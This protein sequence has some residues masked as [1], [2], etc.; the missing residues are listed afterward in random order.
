MS[1]YKPVMKLTDD[2]ARRLARLEEIKAYVPP[3]LPTCY[4]AT[5]TS[6][7]I[8]LWLVLAGNVPQLLEGQEWITLHVQNGKLFRPNL[9]RKDSDQGKA[10]TLLGKLLED[11]GLQGHTGYLGFGV[12]N[13]MLN[14][15]ILLKKT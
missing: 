12:R 5:D 11:V 7:L 6:S 8:N 15:E 2:H 4:T 10:S 14:G 1:C 13:G 9:R 3:P